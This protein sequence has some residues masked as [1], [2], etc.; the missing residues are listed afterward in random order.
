MPG[1]QAERP[2]PR[3]RTGISEVPRC[4]VAPPRLKERLAM[5]GETAAR[6][7]MEP[8]VNRGRG[9]PLLVQA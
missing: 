7:R 5:A 9:L 2:L 1:E 4:G 3:R 8:S 6:S